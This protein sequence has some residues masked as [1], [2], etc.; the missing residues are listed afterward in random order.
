MKEVKEKSEG[1]ESKL[2]EK[3]IKRSV[4]KG[5]EEKAQMLKKIETEA[6]RERERKREWRN[7]KSK[8]Y[9]HLL[10]RSRKWDEEK[11]DNANETVN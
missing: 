6:K 1:A 7:C 9:W 10:K 8:I 4:S 2:G 5:R 3:R 11:R